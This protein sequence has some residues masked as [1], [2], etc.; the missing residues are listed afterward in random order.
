MR[1]VVRELSLE[2]RDERDMDRPR[3]LLTD[4]DDV[5]LAGIKFLL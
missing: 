2:L 5:W 3:N 1:F 4:S